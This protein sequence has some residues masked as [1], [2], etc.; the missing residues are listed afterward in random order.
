MSSGLFVRALTG[1]IAKYNIS[2]LFSAVTISLESSYCLKLK[3]IKAHVDSSPTIVLNFS[4]TGGAF[5]L[6]IDPSE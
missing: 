6:N 2:N 1:I 3:W 4:L 5:W